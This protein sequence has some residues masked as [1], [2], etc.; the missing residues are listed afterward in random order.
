MGA[1]PLGRA[2]NTPTAFPAV[3]PDRAPTDPGLEQFEVARMSL[4][5]DALGP[6]AQGDRVLDASAS[7]EAADTI[8]RRLGRRVDISRTA[9][10][11]FPDGHFAAVIDVDMNVVDLF[12]HFARVA[13][14]LRQR[15]RLVFTTWCGPDDGRAIQTGRAS[16]MHPRAR[17]FGALVSNGFVPYVV[18]DL[19]S[20]VAPSL[21]TGPG[22]PVL[23]AA[24][25]FESQPEPTA[26]RR[27]LRPPT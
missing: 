12:D 26:R 11:R 5:L 14:L 15:G 13:K 10:A 25:R 23:V 2:A 19:T 22:H 16:T 27:R 3:T 6:V 24:E 9:W 18:A 8:R 1:I 20:Q 21:R 4:L 17:Y 7:G